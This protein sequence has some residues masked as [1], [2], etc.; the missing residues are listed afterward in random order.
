MFGNLDNNAMEEILL[1]GFVGRIGCH[2]DDITYVVPTSYAYH[3]S[4]IY[5]HTEEGMKTTIMRK[6][7][8]VCFEVDAME[9]MANW[10]SV[11]A[12]GEYEEITDLPGQEKALNILM[13][14]KLP[15]F[16]SKTV[17]L[18]DEW[19]FHPANPGDVGGIFFR[20]RLTEKT[21]RFETKDSIDK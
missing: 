18:T 5:C 4:C 11:I 1:G 17:K 7:P 2:A 3:D 19:P 20:I 21:G 12:W 15:T 13:D 16:A 8:K 6:N 14:R 9:N 10:K